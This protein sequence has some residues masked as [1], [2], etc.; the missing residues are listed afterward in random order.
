MFD[1]VRNNQRIVQI[2]LGLITL[3][4]AFWGVDSYVRNSGAG[5]D[6]ASVGDTKITVPQFDAALR[7]RQDQMRQALGQNFRPEMLN[8]PDARL[9]VL[10]GMIDQRLLLIESSKNRLVTT[11]EALRD[12]IAKIPALQD[13]G[14]FSMEKYERVLRA[15]GMSQPQF[16]AK[17]RQDLTMRQL[18]G[19]VGD[20]A[21][22]ARAQA[23]TVTN[24]QLEERQF[25]EFRFPAEQF[26]DKV[27]LAADAAQKYYDENKAQFEIAEQV[28]AEFLILSQDAIQSQATVSDAEVKSWYESHKDKYQQAEERRASH[29]LIM[30]KSEGEKAAAK[31]K[32]EDVLKE[33]R[34][35]PAK[36]AE[37]AKQYSQDPG[38]AKSGGDLGYFGRGSMVKAFED[39]VFK[40]KEGEISDVLES[41]FGYHIIK[42]TGIKPGKVRS[43]DEVR[44]DIE[45]DLKRQ[46]ATRKFAEAAEAFNN[47]VYEQSD[48]L[49]PAAEKFKLKIQQSGWLKK[50][51]DPR[52]AAALGPFANEKILGALFSEDSIKGKRNTEA[53]E[54]A[55][56]TLLAARVLEHV[57]ASTKPFESV[58]TDIEKLLKLR[59]AASLAQAAGEARLEELRKGGDDKLAWSASKQASRMAPRDLSPVAVR[60]LFKADTQKLP[61]YV[62][63]SA[64]NGYAIYKIVKVGMPEKLDEARRQALRNEYTRILAQE[65][66]SAYVNALRA[67][68]K[69]DINTAVLESRESR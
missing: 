34:K 43:L 45:S 18:M 21:F 55:Q 47:M 16:E 29:I 3:P 68:T 2:F 58:R 33:V 10:N 60:A 64:G 41:E 38:S 19:T 23:D 24:L 42:L 13:D 57:P 30:A 49:Q 15:Q 26:L 61:A 22:V 7:E 50:N 46:T 44:A 40:Q 56:N 1:A 67:R 65:E 6:V 63:A 39:T 20:S 27:K 5:S 28:K 25:N 4:F 51:P 66:L 69:I 9:S 31:A 14:K 8:T 35:A 54:I 48:S 32:A 12:V 37:F 52:E 36:F 62:G 53:Y 11:D 59:E 17:L